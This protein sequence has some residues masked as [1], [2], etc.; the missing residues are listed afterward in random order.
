MRALSSRIDLVMCIRSAEVSTW[1]RASRAEFVPFL[2]PEPGSGPLAASNDP[3]TIYAAGDAHRDYELLMAATAGTDLSVLVCTRQ[4][5][6]TRG[7]ANIT[8]QGPV[9]PSQGRANQQ[10]AGI[11]TVLLTNTSL[12]AG[13]LVLLD[14]MAAG[15]AIVCSHSPG[16]VDYVR[17]GVD[18]V[19][20]PVAASPE[21]LRRELSRLTTDRGLRERL[22]A[23]ARLRLSGDL[24][25]SRTVA[26]CAQLVEEQR[27]AQS[28]QTARVENQHES[29]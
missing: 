25:A 3:A 9:S 1:R 21:L 28:P 23:A 20:L 2:A 24:H 11:T 12:P 26:R 27:K 7:S 17:D 15:A 18:A 8:V 13:P 10:N 16:L 14:A 5:P 19:V 22:G 29:K 6:N 4:V